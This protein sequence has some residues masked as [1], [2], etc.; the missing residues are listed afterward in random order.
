MLRQPVPRAEFREMAQNRQ[1]PETV[2]AKS[3]RQ[4]GD[5]AQCFL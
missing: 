2:W 3:F 4:G 1:F 5:P